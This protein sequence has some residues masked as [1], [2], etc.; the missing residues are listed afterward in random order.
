MIEITEKTKCCG[1][2]ACYNVCPKR[3]IT[4]E[5]DEEGFLYPQVDRSKCVNCGICNKVCPVEEKP[6][7]SEKI[8][9]AYAMRAKD[10]DVLMSSTSGGFM[11]PL[12]EY[13]LNCEGVICA[14]SYDDNF[15]V[16]HT[17]IDE[18]DEL[19]IGKI[20]GSKYVQSYLGDS[21]SKIKKYLD[22]QRMVCFVGTTCQVN[23][24]K[25]YLRKDYKELITVDL[26]CH[27]SPSPKLWKKYLDFQKEK[28]HSEVQEVVFRNKTYGY[29]SGTMKIRF[30]NG[31]K[32]FGSARVDYMLK[33]FFKEIASRP[34]CYQCP[35]KTLERCSDFTIYDCWHAAEL[36]P[37]LSDD[38]RG[39]TNVMVQSNKG[40][41]ILEKIRESYDIYQVDNQKAIELDGPMVLHS[42][43][44]HNRRDE[45]YM[46][47]DSENL[48]EH[49]NKYIPIT[50]KDILIERAK[51][52]VYKCGLYEK[53]MKLKKTNER[54]E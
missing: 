49:V 50:A 54:K 4:M 37:G 29:H 45:Y 26:V 44:P 9:G 34:I 52:F 33:S 30:A 15:Q 51:I 47:I 19:E 10:S 46:N 7:V 11:T 27:G 20:R 39:Y 35:F 31:K 43:I 8:C 2:T 25:A 32:Y 53:V 28:Y 41:K 48:K 3:A 36:V 24:L 6:K 21:F 17:I 42:A 40:K 1:C 5:A 38:D 12:I 14:A 22:E 23:G 16:V 18:K 13:V